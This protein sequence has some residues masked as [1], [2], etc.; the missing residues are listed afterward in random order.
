MRTIGAQIE[1]SVRV[2]LESKGLLF[3]C[4]NYYSKYGEIDLIMRENSTLVFIEIRY[5]KD[6]GYGD[7]L[8]TVTPRKQ[9][10]IKKTAFCY[11]KKTQL[12]DK[13][14]CRF[15]VVSV[16]KEENGLS[17]DWIQ[18]AFWENW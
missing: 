9:D 10:K 2:Y 17:I 13:T 1:K 16:A 4:A 11:L 14:N 7:G 18:D 5:R 3:V 8:S 6:N 15:D 12:F